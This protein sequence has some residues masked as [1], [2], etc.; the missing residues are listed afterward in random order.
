MKLDVL[1]FGAHPDDVELGCGGTMAK[2]AAAGYSTGIVDLTAGELGTRGNSELRSAE[3]A[4][5]AGI[6]KIKIREN[7]AMRDGFFDLSEEHKLSIARVVRKYRPDVVFC[8]AVS[9][10]HPD[11]GRASQLISESCFLAGLARIQMNDEK[12]TLGPW[13]PRSVFHY[14]QDRYIK[15]D[16]IVDVSE[17]WKTKMEAVSAFS[18]QFHNPS[19]N[20]PQTPLTSP[21]FFDF[22]RARAL[23]YG[24]L[25]GADYGEGFTTERTIGVDDPFLLK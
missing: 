7:L 3:A 24:R 1:A 16:F 17:F 23:E 2:M 21:L 25:I 5:A 9:D 20:E 4:K 18:S 14:I 8:N 15:P 6:L 13:R 12:G 19:S 10:R 22:I 11:H